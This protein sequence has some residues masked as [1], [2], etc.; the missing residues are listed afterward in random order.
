MTVETTASSGRSPFFSVVIPA[1]NRAK[2][3]DRTL[4]SVLAQTFEDFECLVIDDGSKDSAELAKLVA[5]YGDSR[6]KYFRQENGGASAARNTGAS[7]ASG[8]YVV[9][10][11]SDD[12]FLPEKLA[13]TEKVLRVTPDIGV[14]SLSYVDRGVGRYWLRP[15][16]A[17]LPDEDM[18]DYLFIHNQFIPTSTLVVPRTMATEVQFDTELRHVEDPD[19]CYRLYRAGLRFRM[20]EKPLTLWSDVSGH[21]RLSQEPTSDSPFVWLRKMRGTLPKRIERG[22]RVTILANYLA[23]RRPLTV[24]R[25]LFV[26][27]MLA[28]VPWRV[29]ARQAVRSFMPKALYRTLVNSYLRSNGLVLTLLIPG[30]YN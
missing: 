9:Y 20:I 17:I 30:I 21:A 25:D 10:L 14:Y 5:S 11:D 16:R 7:L 3:I 13:E 22:Y 23:H 28:G 8:R 12:L 2:I 29:V 26:G 4:K 1:Y 18:G 19:F 27:W 24:I 15:D 6:L